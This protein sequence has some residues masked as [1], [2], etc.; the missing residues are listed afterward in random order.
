MVETTP[1][2]VWGGCT[3]L[4]PL[5]KFLH[6]LKLADKAQQSQTTKKLSISL[7]NKLSKM[8]R[9]YSAKQFC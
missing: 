8:V 7:N 9:S 4:G 2:V 3:P 6:F 1:M 5:V